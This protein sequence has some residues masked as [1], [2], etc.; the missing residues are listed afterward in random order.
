LSA[1]LLEVVGGARSSK[2]AH[3]LLGLGILAAAPTVLSGLAEFG[4]IRDDRDR[5]VAAVHAA[6]NALAVVAFSASWLARRRHRLRAVVWGVTGGTLVSVTGYLGGHL[7]YGRGVGVGIRGREDGDRSAGAQPP[8][9]HVSVPEAAILLTVPEPQVW[10]MIDEGMLTRV[11][12][13][14]TPHLER[15]EVL[16]MRNLGG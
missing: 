14:G 13:G 6:G 11:D 4:N 1:G 3:R 9:D 8:A 15:A 7:S 16:A 2:A 5:R 10:A 12:C